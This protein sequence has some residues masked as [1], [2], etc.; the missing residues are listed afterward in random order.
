[1]GCL[2]SATTLFFLSQE[3]GKGSREEMQKGEGQGRE[4]GRRLGK[5]KIPLSCA[6]CTYARIHTRTHGRMYLRWVTQEVAGVHEERSRG[7]GPE[8]NSK[9]SISRRRRRIRKNTKRGVSNHTLGHKERLSSETTAAWR[10]QERVTREK[11]RER[12]REQGG[13]SQYNEVILLMPTRMGG[14]GSSHARFFLALLFQFGRTLEPG[15]MER[16]RRKGKTAPKDPAA[17]N[18]K[19]LTTCDAGAA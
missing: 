5:A 8:G 13:N 7:G 17:G 2:S 1:M 3:P 4:K 14:K 18:Q 16:P 11:K 9:S 6:P 15:A 12:E 10:S 19:Y